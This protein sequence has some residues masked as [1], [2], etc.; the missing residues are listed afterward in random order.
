M[1][2]LL[3][4]TTQAGVLLLTDIE[5]IDYGSLL[6]LMIGEKKHSKFKLILYTDLSYEK[7][8]EEIL[9]K[10]TPVNWRS[11]VFESQSKLLT[12]LIE[13]NRPDLVVRRQ[14]N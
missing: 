6:R 2:D 4:A 8:K 13:V 1:A 11:S 7:I 9:S 14:E 3:E 10:T 12:K 5:S